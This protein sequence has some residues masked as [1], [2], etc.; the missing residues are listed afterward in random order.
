LS[1]NPD[2]R[3]A[4]VPVQA[5]PTLLILTALAS[6]AQA[7]VAHGKPEVGL[8][9]PP[10]ELRRIW[11]AGKSEVWAGYTGLGADAAR[12]A[13][14]PFKGERAPKRIV[15]AGV[16]GA[17]RGDLDVGDLVV[18]EGAVSEGGGLAETDTGF[19]AAVEAALERSGLASRRRGMALEVNRVVGA[20]DDKRA[21]ARRFPD[22]CVVAMEDRAA[23]AAARE[24]GAEVAA[25]RVVIDR[26]GDSLP[27]LSPG[28]DAAGRPRALKLAAHLVRQPGAL[29]ALPGLA[30]SFGVARSV[31]ERALHAVLEL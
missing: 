21:L 10:G 16:A 28:L 30:R 1:W 8:V 23:I 4:A 3:F 31:L 14:L 2:P 25:F 15:F 24:I 27:D 6:E 26:L 29:R 7:L 12:A 22:A 19:T 5:S 18:L 11:R 13:I 17:L 9:P 20:P